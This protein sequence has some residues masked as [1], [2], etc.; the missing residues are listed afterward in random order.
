MKNAITYYKGKKVCFF[1]LFFANTYMKM[2]LKNANFGEAKLLPRHRAHE[3]ERECTNFLLLL[4]YIILYIE[5]T[6]QL[7]EISTI[8]KMIN[9]VIQAGAEKM[10]IVVD[11]KAKQDELH[12]IIR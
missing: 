2:L 9:D 12:E 10:K 7:Q 1:H 8:E 3:Y 4:N 11:L 6:H 5:W